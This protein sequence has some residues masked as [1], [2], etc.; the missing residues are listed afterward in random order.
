M[1]TKILRTISNAAE[2]VSDSKAPVD[3]DGGYP[4]PPEISVDIN[5][6]EGWLKTGP[7]FSIKD[8]PAYV[9]AVK[10]LNSVGINDRK[11]FL[12]KLLTLMARLGDGNEFSTQLQHFVIDA[13]Y[14]DLPHPPS[15]YL[16][17]A[18]APTPVS[19]PLGVP[20][21]YRPADGSNYNPLFP[22]LGQ[23]GAPYARSVPSSNFTPQRSLPDA[24]L[25]FDTLLKRD[26]FTPHPGGISSLFFAFADLIIHSI[27]NT[28]PR[29]WTKNEVSSYLDLSVL[30]GSSDKD[31]ASVRKSDGTGKIWEDSFADPRLLF[32]PPSV[33]ALLVIFSRNHNYVAEKLLAINE[34]GTYKD[35]ASLS[36]DALAAQD[37][38][39]FQRTRLVNS[40]FFVQAI[41]A[42]YVGAILGLVRDG[43]TWRLNPLD[44]MRQLDHEFSP[45]GEG[46]VVS[47]EFNLL[48]RWH[49]TTSQQDT[50]WTED[51]F[52]EVF[53]GKDFSTITVDDF[54]TIAVQ[55]MIP[56][57]PPKE[58][59]F[60]GLTR[61][62]KTGKFSDAALAKIL[63]DATE[64][65]A[66]A[67]KARGTPEVLRV[68]EI[69][70]IEQSR[71]W[72]ACSLNE[73]RKF[74]GLKEYDNFA[75]WNPDPVINKAAEALYGH[76]D[77][78]EL[79]VGMQ[80][81]EAKVPMPGA[82]L[83]PGYTISRAIL[84]DAVC[85][86]RGDRFLTVDNTPFNL[87]SWGYQDCQIDKNDGS[88][89]GM[90]TKMLFR[91][92][93]DYYPRNSTY[94]FF[95][96]LVPSSMK[97]FAEKL[98]DGTVNKY[99]WTRPTAPA[100][101][102]K[103]E[104]FEGVS[105]VLTSP[106]NF[107]PQ[108]RTR[109]EILSKGAAANRKLV[110]GTLFNNSQIAKWRSSF[111]QTTLG[112]IKDKSVSHVGSTARYVDVVKDVVNLVP[113]HWIANEVVGV[114]M[115]TTA[116]PSGISREQDLYNKFADVCNYIFLNYDPYHDL[117]LHND[118]AKT[119]AEIAGTLKS[120]LERLKDGLFSISGLVDT[121]KHFWTGA[122]DHSDAFLKSLL[123][124]NKNA[125]LDDLAKAL[126]LEVVGTAALYSKAIAHVIDF[127]LD[128]DAACKDILQL[129]TVNTTASDAKLSSYIREALRLKPV[130][131][132]VYSVAQHDAT[133]GPQTKVSKGTNVYASVIKAD[134]DPSVF[135]PDPT[136][137]NFTRPVA[138]LLGLED[139]GLLTSSFF[140]K[141]A[142]EVLIAVLTLKS[143][144]RAPGYSG[145]FN[146]FTQDQSGSKE[147]LYINPGGVVTPW[148]SSLVLQYTA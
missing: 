127:Y 7:P 27:F 47:L 119:I 45:Q 5:E 130:V 25:L 116:N 80:A 66:S 57:T 14:K 58:W 88:F 125:N 105:W 147:V 95:P 59:T 97:G 65:S 12:E 98:G 35:P 6:L 42:D 103:V 100:P 50:K 16:S 15:S 135:G 38:E 69:M 31:V 28:N 96:F 51:L 79:H 70:G 22:T 122:N 87:T 30:Y 144:A 46:N 94:A 89:G 107:L 62:E 128:Q 75:E 23:A 10:N 99:S 29:D 73:F 146:T 48:Y 19:A 115:K 109:M 63:Q 92:L 49:A 54:K 139:Y 129:A 74:M 41:F 114:S 141:T 131:S 112:L 120:H 104:T 4:I 134:L 138:G 26:K 133:V 108:S 13:L 39:I 76:I 90:L 32:M 72:G 145:I 67:F 60:D 21:A 3:E 68:I 142:S 85:L 143:V 123:S 148:P 121:T 37:E 52:Q 78:L 55:K 64:W 101:T 124:A 43:L 132:G 117:E 34:K 137:P 9:D 110:D 136:T 24:G 8:I 40:G 83:C 1:A 17:L 20:Y 86:T 111:R 56:K 91:H 126:V 53:S 36:G 18:S 93:P 140:E 11:F 61:D 82:G 81:E 106:Q 2:Y 118:A 44:T 102:I 77:N 113:I 84:A 71:S 33:C